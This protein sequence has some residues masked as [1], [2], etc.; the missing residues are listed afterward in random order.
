MQIHGKEKHLAMLQSIIP[1]HLILS[2]Q[3]LP[4]AEMAGQ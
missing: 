3:L 1:K 4:D 2:T